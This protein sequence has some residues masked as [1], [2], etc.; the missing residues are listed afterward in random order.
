MNK[1][2]KFQNPLKVYIFHIFSMFLYF[3]KWGFYIISCLNKISTK[4]I[5]NINKIKK[6]LIFMFSLYLIIFLFFMISGPISYYNISQS[7]KIIF[8]ILTI[9]MIA[10]SI[11]WFIGIVLF[12]GFVN[13]Q[14]DR[15][16][17]FRFG[18]KTN[19]ILSSLI[20]VLLF[21]I[22]LLNVPYTQ[23]K[24]NK[25]IKI[26]YKNEDECNIQNNEDNKL[27][28]I[29]PFKII[30]FIMILF[31]LY[32]FGN[33]IFKG[34][35]SNNIAIEIKPLTDR[36]VNILINDDIEKL[37][38]N[39]GRQSGLTEEEF[40]IKFYEL[41]KIFGDITDFQYRRYSSSSYKNKLTG[42]FIYYKLYTSDGNSY[43]GIFSMDINEEENKPSRVKIERFSVSG[44]IAD[45]RY[46]YI[47][48][49]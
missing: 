46:F 20:A 35:R 32:V 8:D 4:E 13:Y 12:F 34:I 15:I 27:K 30:I 45:K 16:S 23:Y 11:L 21:P 14:I 25:L 24:L 37:H 28:K 29:T 10:I 2:I 18:L 3:F 39:F 19:P 40:S 49:M 43:Q 42:F 41:K 38:K 44:D 1:T 9:I 6:I 48:L 17:S 47:D 31:V 26:Q 5:I 36:F 7:L 33:L 22:F